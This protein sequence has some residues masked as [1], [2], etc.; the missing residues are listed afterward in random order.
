MRDCKHVF[1]LT[2]VLLAGLACSARTQQPESIA[3]TVDPAQVIGRVD[4]GIYGQFLEHIFNSVHGGLWGDLILNPSLESTSGGGWEITDNTVRSTG[5][6]TDQRL[7]F[8]DEQWGDYELQLE[9]RKLEGAEGFLV[10]FRAAGEG[11]FHWANLGG[12]QNR[13]HGFEKARGPLGTRVPGT[14]EKGR[15]YRVRVRCEGP[16]YQV[17]LDNQKVLDA[18]DSKEPI[19]RGAVGV[20]GWDT[21][22][23]FRAIKVTSLEGKTLFEGLPARTALATAPAYWKMFGTADF[24]ADRREPF[25]GG[26]SMR[27]VRQAGT[28]EAGLRQKPIFL[29]GGEHYRGSVWLKGTTENGV[30]VRLMDERGQAVFRQELRDFGKNWKKQAFEFTTAQTVSNAAFEIA[31]AGAG[32]VSVDMASLFPQRALDAGGFR[33]DVLQAIK[34]LKPASIRYPGGCFASAYRWKDGIG[35]RDKRVYYPN[36]IWSDQDPNQMGTDEFMDLC[37]RVGAEPILPINMT[38][39]VPEALDWLEYC[40]GSVDTKWGSERAKNGHPQPY[41]VKLWEIDNETWGMGAERYAEV[42]TQF[43]RALR[44]KDPSVKIIACGGY[45]YDDGKGSSKDWNRKLLEKAAQDFDYLSIHYYNGIMYDQDC[46]EDPR[47]YEAYMRDEIGS[48]IRSSA[49]P[50]IRIYCSEWGMMNDDWRSG[51][52]TGGILNGFERLGELVPMTCPAVWLQSVSATRPQPRW[53]SCL[54][55]FD[56]QNCYGAPTWVVE[57][58]WRE[59]FAPKR[60]K[61]DGPERPLN[62]IATLSEDGQTLY[63]KSVNPTSQTVEVDFKVGESFVPGA[64]SMQI[65]SGAATDHNSLAEPRKLAPKAVLV[66]REGQHVRFAMPPLSAGVLRL[67]TKPLTGPD[68]TGPA[69][70]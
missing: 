40:N 50:A 53:A 63:L 43:S 8:G 68:S 67:S 31:L 16:R 12:W 4:A 39:G 2:A 13:E 25:N 15:W 55:L 65:V 59:H 45:G 66:K 36:V 18:T 23:Q 34:D 57:K 64:A 60:V 35:L 69:S 10:L 52:Y 41:R 20:A 49:N 48:L 3:Y 6:I 62:Q 30:Q 47:R 33:P 58:L 1:K 21:Q 22:V 38:T 24:T 29:R 37:R 11:R 61:L 19:L 9:A 5:R 32:D 28:G 14:I 26:T 27:M 56:H 70:R 54:I 7:V 51:L 42:V 44:E 46:V 17:W